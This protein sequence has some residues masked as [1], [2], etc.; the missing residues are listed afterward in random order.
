MELFGNSFNTIPWRHVNSTIVLPNGDPDPHR[1]NLLDN[2][3]WGFF[4]HDFNWTQIRLGL[5]TFGEKSLSD[6]NLK[7]HVTA[8]IHNPGGTEYRAAFDDFNIIIKPNTVGLSVVLKYGTY[9]TF[10]D[11]NYYG[12]DNITRDYYWGDILNFT[13]CAQ[14]MIETTIESGLSMQFVLKQGSKIITQG[15]MNSTAIP[16]QYTGSLDTN[17]ASIGI[18]ADSYE[19]YIQGIKMN[20]SVQQFY[21]VIDFL[22]RDTWLMPEK[23]AGVFIENAIYDYNSI[24]EIMSFY[25]LKTFRPLDDTFRSV[26]NATIRMNVTLEDHSPRHSGIITE[27]HVKWILSLAGVPRLAGWTNSS[28]NGVFCLTVDLH[29]L[30][31][32]IQTE[33][34]KSFSL[35]VIPYKQNFESTRNNQYP[36]G[37]TWSVPIRIGHR[38]IILVAI[39]PQS[40]TWSQSNWKYHPLIFVAMD[41]ISGENISGCTINWKI[42]G[43]SL[44]QVYMDEISGMPGYYQVVFDT[45]SSPFNWIAGGTYRLS[46]E[47]TTTPNP[48]YYTYSDGWVVAALHDQDRPYLTV[49][50]EGFLGPLSSYFYII[51]GVIGAVVGGYYSYKSYKFLTTPYV[52]RKIEESIDKISKDKKIAAGVMKSRD[53]LIFLEATDLLKVVG[54]E[55][56]P[57]PEKK[58]PPVIEKLAPK[59]VAAEVE[60]ITELPPDVISE[61]LD[62]AGVR[63]EEKPTML[64][65]IKEL[66]PEDRREF[67][68]GLIGEDRYKELVEKLKQK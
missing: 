62:K 56:R 33:L 53:H 11:A 18:I 22:E 50:S 48:M 21:K 47:I 26:P 32:D 60:K 68:Q 31:L 63:P 57:P 67:I 14:D 3:T 46:A 17:N 58:L 8:D 66:G 35:Q 15:I 64:Q 27:A 49:E 36:S 59:K 65:Q 25:D 29:D 43:T 39:T 19:L 51:L 24:D 34:D 52:I 5:G 28:I 37:S 10:L 42:E 40:M 55:L 16:G 45:W 38:P 23:I 6:L 9:D 41:P 12:A 4:Y 7:I 61:E 2:T 44:Q 30:N 13:I 1:E 20:H 54:V